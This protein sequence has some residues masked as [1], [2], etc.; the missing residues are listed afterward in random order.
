MLIQSKLCLSTVL[1]IPRHRTLTN[2]VTL[3]LQN[4]FFN[5]VPILLNTTSYLIYATKSNTSISTAVMDS[6][7]FQ[8]FNQTGDISNSAY[9]QNGTT[10]L[11][12][13]L[14]T[15]GA[16]YLTFFANQAPAN[17]SYFYDIISNVQLQNSTTFVGRYA[18]LPPLSQLPL[19]VH[20]ETLGS[21]TVIQLFGV[22]NQSV[23]YSLFDNSTG[24]QVFTSVKPETDKSY[25]HGI[26]ECEPWLQRQPFKRALHFI[27]YEQ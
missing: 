6:D 27:H 25:S 10:N 22:S 14:L 21:P 12:A 13:L 16:Y 2:N 24:S 19:L 11:N 9:D 20:L 7:Q 18:T 15:Q 17:I 1:L 8:S 5:Y 23:S 26:G 3:Q 4:N